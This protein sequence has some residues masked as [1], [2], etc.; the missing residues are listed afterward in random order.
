[1]M[2]RRLNSRITLFTKSR[3]KIPNHEITLNKTRNYLVFFRVTSWFYLIKI[4]LV[5]TA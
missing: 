5:K 1:M 4:V 2:G 3:S